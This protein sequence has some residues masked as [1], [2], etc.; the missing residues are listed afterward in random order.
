VLEK[1]FCV[2]QNLSRQKMEGVQWNFVVREDEVSSDDEDANE[3][4]S[5]HVDYSRELIGYPVVCTNFNHKKTKLR[6]PHSEVEWPESTD[7][8]AETLGQPSLME[9]ILDSS[10]FLEQ[11]LDF[12]SGDDLQN[13]LWVSHEVRRCVL[14]LLPII[15]IRRFKC[16][17]QPFP[18]WMSVYMPYIPLCPDLD[19]WT[20]PFFTN[21]EKTNLENSNEYTISE[22]NENNDEQDIIFPTVKSYKK[23]A[24]PFDIVWILRRFLVQLFLHEALMLVE[25]HETTENSILN[26]FKNTSGI[27]SLTS[28]EKLMK[29][30]SDMKTMILLNQCIPEFINALEIQCPWPTPVTH[31]DPSI[32]DVLLHSTSFVSSLNSVHPPSYLSLKHIS[33][34]GLGARVTSFLHM[35]SVSYKDAFSPELS[36]SNLGF[37]VP[38]SNFVTKVI[39]RREAARNTLSAEYTLALLLSAIDCRYLSLCKPNAVQRSLDAVFVNFCCANPEY[40]NVVPFCALHARDKAR[41]QR[42]FHGFYAQGSN[43]CGLISAWRTQEKEA[44][45]DAPIFSEQRQKCSKCMPISYHPQRPVSD[46][47]MDHLARSVYSFFHANFTITPSFFANASL[48]IMNSSFR[49]MRYDNLVCF[50]AQHA[51]RALGLVS[52]P[53]F[54]EICL[55]FA[56]MVPRS[57]FIKTMLKLLSHFEYTMLYDILTK[58]IVLF[59]NCTLYDEFFGFTSTN[60]FK[61]VTSRYKHCEQSAGSTNEEKHSFASAVRISQHLTEAVV[62]K[63]SSDAYYKQQPNCKLE[64]IGVDTTSVC[65]GIFSNCVV[66]TTQA[67]MPP[68]CFR[69][70]GYNICSCSMQDVFSDNQSHSEADLSKFTT[71]SSLV[72]ANPDTIDA[73]YKH[74]F[75]WATYRDAITSKNGNVNAE[76]IRSLCGLIH[77]IGNPSSQSIVMHDETCCTA[78]RI[79]DLNKTLARNLFDLILQYLDLHPQECK[80]IGCHVHSNLEHCTNPSI[81]TKKDVLHDFKFAT[82]MADYP[83]QKHMLLVHVY[84]HQFLRNKRL[85][86]LFEI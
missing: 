85:E 81:L 57:F 16:I 55:R 38:E 36:W 6:C 58:L 80:E 70:T 37:H 56:Y 34:I 53:I 21:I 22:K 18:I 62:C 71:E 49:C 69:S 45:F 79:R 73:I 4:D 33:N 35:I 75:P 14:E 15:S 9:N 61:S 42:V 30:L 74:A 31:L 20:S 52:L 5:D 67:S 64:P 77:C 7:T 19:F 54:H 66:T 1:L 63:F 65:S 59:P 86:F 11:V 78:S 25:S 84:I 3:Y 17:T 39:Y 47:S 72:V 23:K 28:Q 46:Q 76:H 60:S 40:T 26:P 12:L 32:S 51:Q 44:C 29:N 83:T 8:L 2:C 68:S 82:K 50:A 43:N 10:F 13:L 41:L 48:T 27:R 24:E